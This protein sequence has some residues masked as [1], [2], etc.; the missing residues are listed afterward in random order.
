[1]DSTAS[2]MMP[3]NAIE[4]KSLP[5]FDACRSPAHVPHQTL[6]PDPTMIST[7]SFAYKGRL[8]KKRHRYLENAI[9]TE[10]ASFEIPDIDEENAPLAMWATT[11]MAPT[12]GRRAI[13]ASDGDLYEPVLLTG[14]DA[15]TP[16]DLPDV[17][18]R[19]SEPT[20]RRFWRATSAAAPAGVVFEHNVENDGSEHTHLR[21]PQSV[22]NL[23]RYG[24]RAEDA[25]E[26]V[27]TDPDLRSEAL[28][29]VRAHVAAEYRNIGG[30]LFRKTKPSM[31]RNYGQGTF[32]VPFDFQHY[33]GSL[34]LL[35]RFDTDICIKTAALGKTGIDIADMVA[36]PV[37]PGAVLGDERPLV[38]AGTREALVAA[39]RS[40]LVDKRT[41]LDPAS[42]VVILDLMERVGSTTDDKL[43]E[44]V[45][46]L[47]GGSQETLVR[48]PRLLKAIAEVGTALRWLEVGRMG[49]A[50]ATTI[51]NLSLVVANRFDI[52]TPGRTGRRS[53]A[54]PVAWTFRVEKVSASDH[55]VVASFLG[56]G[57]QKG[58]RLDVRSSEGRFY[59]PVIAADTPV[60]HRSVRKGWDAA[61]HGEV[62]RDLQAASGSSSF[63][64][65]GARH[66]TIDEHTFLV[67]H[68]TADAVDRLQHVVL[69]EL[70]RK[71]L[72][73]DGII[74]RE[75]PEPRIAIHCDFSGLPHPS[76]SLSD[77]L[78]RGHIDK[79]C[80]SLQEMDLV[81]ELP[82]G[83]GIEGWANELSTIGVVDPSVFSSD[84][85]SLRADVVGR[86]VVEGLVRRI[87]ALDP[88]DIVAMS[89]LRALL[90][91]TG[92]AAEA[93][94]VDPEAV[95]ALVAEVREAFAGLDA[96][97]AR[98][99]GLSEWMVFDTETVIRPGSL[100]VDR[101]NVV[102][103]VYA[104]GI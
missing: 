73:I 47:A 66:R 91:P 103:P 34:P 2:D 81:K 57:K 8:R 76:L 95:V 38:L 24:L 70:P 92:R 88:A 40:D 6:A 9:F 41:G 37:G 11:T 26:I 53:V 30:V 78:S 77:H 28:A 16:T 20:D 39:C 45:D 101:E 25:G 63:Y 60:Q 3:T 68:W 43:P 49:D 86:K 14:N 87:S 15:T 62:V 71:L 23:Q 32:V 29:H 4:E 36:R 61:I 69:D 67:P 64:Q 27:E 21:H 31:L 102:D 82:M 72:A 52:E 100:Q 55:P 51:N 54:H 44:L 48:F 17:F 74:H 7:F 19:I 89:R 99:T 93:E 46:L 84:M 1:M 83:D 104:L 79:L 65:E 94:K 75:I 42:T 98:A 90:A 59:L 10:T 12:A 97:E 33:A 22:S 56:G 5:P 50:P 18:D 58:I 35:R 13:R 96:D 80:F 85:A